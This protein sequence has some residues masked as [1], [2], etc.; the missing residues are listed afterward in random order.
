MSVENLIIS[1]LE[2]QIK[3][4]NEL[5]KS[6]EIIEKIYVE[7][8]NARDNNNK[9]FI[10]GN[11]G[12]A[13][14]SSHFVSDLLKTSLTKENK[15]TKAISLTDNIPVIMAWA[16]DT[17]FKNIFY[18]QLENF[19][20]KGDV[21]IGISGSGNSENVIKAIEF[22]N[23]KEAKT[24]CLSGMDGGK[25]AKITQLSLIIPNNDMLTIET[26]HLLICHLLTSLLRSEGT[27]LFSY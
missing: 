6:K 7:I 19:L 2:D 15:R 4:I 11:G 3:S 5:K 14:T 23:T 27:P 1:N 22:A 20:Q 21:V 25:L 9:I 12:S 18:A 24:I 16:N 8:K 10:M 13:S 17:S 26:M